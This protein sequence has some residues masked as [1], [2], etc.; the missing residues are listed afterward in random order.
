[1]SG[2]SL[3]AALDQGEKCNFAIKDTNPDDGSAIPR[4]Y[5]CEWEL[6]IDLLKV[7]YLSIKRDHYPV[8]ETIE[9][10]I[11]GES[12][13]EQVTDIELASTDPENPWERYVLLET[14]TL[15]IFARNK[16][17]TYEST[18]QITLEQAENSAALQLFQQMAVILLSMLCCCL[19][20]SCCSLLCRLKCKKS[21]RINPEDDDLASE[22]ASRQSGRRRDPPPA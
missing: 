18:F 3:S 8:K 22:N 21:E 9:L 19:C 6:E 15:Q 17:N 13:E 7:Y 10:N 4:N 12:K 5:F 11:I 14:K 20:I 1:M 2:G 16:Y